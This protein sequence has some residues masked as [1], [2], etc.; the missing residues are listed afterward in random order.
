MATMNSDAS[1]AVAIPNNLGTML[2]ALFQ[3]GGTQTKS[4]PGDTT[5]L[6]AV[7]KQLQGADYQAM[8]Q[9]IFQQAGQQVPGL[10]GA[11][12]SAVG[13]RSTKNSAVEQALAKLL[14]Q[15]T[16]LGQDQ[17]AK[18][19]L[20][21][22]QVQTQAGSAVAQATKGT[23]QKTGLDMGNT[24]KLLAL[25]QVLGQSG[26][27]KKLTE[28]SGGKAAPAAAAEAPSIFSQLAPAMMGPAAATAAPMNIPS[29]ITGLPELIG[30][31]FQPAVSAIP[32]TVPAATATQP[33]VSQPSAGSYIQ[34][35]FSQLFQP[36]GGQALVGGFDFGAPSL[37]S[38][39][40]DN[41]DYQDWFSDFGG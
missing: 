29:I 38:V 26:L 1:G 30:S 13:A 37:D 23:T 39:T 19:Q 6:A 12:T 15:T 25:A 40:L 24:A 27:L 32:G 2:S 10:L 36:G 4:N 17:L 16:L 11:Y 5:A 41:T 14:Q 34:P 31:A 8:L 20:Q 22:Q 18:Q 35:D 3:A 9:S 28:S 21:N 33:A 7:L